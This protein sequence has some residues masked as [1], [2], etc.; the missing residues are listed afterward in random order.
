MIKKQFIQFYKTI[1]EAIKHDTMTLPI[2]V[3]CRNSVSFYVDK[4]TLWVY[5]DEDD[6]LQ[7]NINLSD[8][9]GTYIPTKEYAAYINKV[10]KG[11]YATLISET[12]LTTLSRNEC[13][14][15]I[16]VVDG[17]VVGYTQLLQHITDCNELSTI[18]YFC[19]EEQFGI[20]FTN[21]LSMITHGIKRGA[22]NQTIPILLTNPQFAQKDKIY[23]KL[24]GEQVV[25]FSSIT[26][27]YECETDYIPEEWHERIMIAL[28]CD[29]VYI[30]GERVTKS[31]NYDID[32]EHCTMS[33]CGVRLT[34][35][36]F[37]VKTNITQR[38][39]N[40]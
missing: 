20:P 13:F 11:I 14:R 37:K 38:N 36:T 5:M 27:E 30:N 22:V 17:D 4:E 39:S 9:Y 33:D 28:A 19:N 35:A 12:L 23:E 7:I 32:H 10:D 24:N 29:E 3:N 25:L 2:S 18:S 8:Q 16:L 40:Y 21:Y 31:E 6:Q 26:K 1:D 15:L 34:R